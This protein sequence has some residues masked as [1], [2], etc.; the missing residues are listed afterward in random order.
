MLRMRPLSVSLI[1]RTMSA[2]SI[3]QQTSMENTTFLVESL[4]FILNSGYKDQI[5]KGGLQNWTIRAGVVRYF[6]ARGRMKKASMV[7]E[8]HM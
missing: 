8:C 7:V 6:V 2:P 4:L 3:S 5:F 1:K